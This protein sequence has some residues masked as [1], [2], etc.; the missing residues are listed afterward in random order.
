MAHGNHPVLTMCADASVVVTDPQNNRKL[1]K[2]KS[3]RRIDG[4]VALAM[5]VGIANLEEVKE[6]SFEMFVLS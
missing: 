3:T 4:M 2:Q 5:A 6:P 1:S